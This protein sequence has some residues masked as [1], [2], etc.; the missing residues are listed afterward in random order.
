VL[1]SYQHQ[2]KMPSQPK[3]VDS[4][5]G[6]L[7]VVACINEVPITTQTRSTTVNL[8]LVATI[9]QYHLLLCWPLLAKSVM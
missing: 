8:S 2:I 1:C 4:V 5:S 3:G 6:G 7:A 9:L